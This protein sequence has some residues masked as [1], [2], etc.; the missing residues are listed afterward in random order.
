[1]RD[2]L[3]FKNKKCFEMKTYNR[4]LEVIFN[5]LLV[6]LL[7]KETFFMKDAQWYLINIDE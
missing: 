1:M 2:R 3:L 6:N 7:Q 5:S 4:K